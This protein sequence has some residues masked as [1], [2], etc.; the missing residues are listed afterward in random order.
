MPNP[1]TALNGVHPL[2]VSNIRPH[3][4]ASVLVQ[5]NANNFVWSIQAR[6]NSALSFDDLPSATGVTGLNTSEFRPCK[7]TEYRVVVTDLGTATAIYVRTN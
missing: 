4:V 3:E 2:D 7:D 6:A 1:I 5:G